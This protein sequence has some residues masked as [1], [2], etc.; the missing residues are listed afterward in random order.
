MSRSRGSLESG[1]L[2]LAVRRMLDFKYR[3]PD[4]FGEALQ[5]VIVA[6]V[7]SEIAGAE[8][9]L[10]IPRRA[11]EY[12]GSNPLLNQ[13]PGCQGDGTAVRQG[14]W[15]NTAIELRWQLAR[16]GCGRY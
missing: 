8:T 15:E 16:C 5:P 14:V 1:S 2:V 10:D 11:K 13:Q 9:Q 4:G 3:A 7:G 12:S 6:D